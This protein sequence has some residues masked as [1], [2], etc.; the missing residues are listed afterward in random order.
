MEGRGRP[1]A[2]VTPRPAIQRRHGKG[3]GA[4][5]PA[6]ARA[7]GR[8]PRVPQKLD[9]AALW[10][11]GLHKLRE[12]QM[13]YGF[14][15]S[16][17]DTGL[18]ACLFGRDSLWTLLLVLDAAELREE[19]EFNAW[20]EVAGATTLAS[21]AAM[22]GS[23]VNDATEEQPG[24][25]LHEYHPGGRLEQR[26]IDSGMPF[27]EGRTYSGFDQTF[28]FV[29]AVKR[30]LDV[31]P[32]NE[33]VQGLWPN[34][35]RALEWT[36]THADED[37]DGIFEYRRRDDRNLKNQVWKDSFDS[38]TATGFDVPPHPLAWIEVQAY[39]YR[40]F[41]DAAHLYSIRGLSSLAE[42]YGAR[43]RL[44]RDQVNDRFWIDAEDCFAM[45]LDGD[46]VPIR[47]IGSNPGHALWAGLLDRPRCEK[48][49]DRLFQPDLMTP[50]GLRTLSAR[51]H[52]YAP[53]AYHRGNVWPFDNAIFAAGL[54][55]A[56]Y[57]ARARA[58][59][60]GVGEALLTAGTPLE[61]YVVLDP[62]IYIARRASEPALAYYRFSPPRPGRRFAPQNQNQA[63]TAAAMLFFAA[64]LSRDYADS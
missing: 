57:E 19:R 41:L 35:E 7:A 23:K 63:W 3:A 2:T 56:G 15:A 47:M 22:Q 6:P 59:M 12:L 54:L 36:K 31:F 46:K 28:L 45:A 64:A 58:V 25:V 40:T 52:F 53:F 27:E 60:Q 30:F 21:L 14:A 10:D 48:L 17:A 61:V 13:D 38:I 18:F 11:L 9:T 49:V 20:V 29:I 62:E 1:P 16:E 37:D 51:S 39:A 50:Y 33:V 34:V 5:T 24:K 55:A 32:G 44:L 4:I 26:H 8:L 42:H 43:A